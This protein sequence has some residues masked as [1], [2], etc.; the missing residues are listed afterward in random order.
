MRKVTL[1]VLILLVG[2][3]GAWAQAVTGFTGG[4][5]YSSY[6]GGTVAGDVVGYRFTVSSPLSVTELGV[7]NADTA[8]GGAGM[9]SSHETGIWD[10]SQTLLASVTVIPGGPVVGN[11][12]YATIT[13]VVLSPGET[14]TIGTIYT[15]TDNDN[16]ISSASS[17]T[18]A[19]EVTFL[20]SVYPAAIDLGFVY[21]TMDSSSFGR[22]GPNFL[23]TVVPV[24]LQSFSIE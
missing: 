18:T 19:P 2:A 20:N 1:V 3:T 7:W 9:T 15:T 11:W 24:E 17:M 13:P 10:S 8:A 14:Y 23:F 4:T 16:Y 6:Y 12:V 22:F 21:P 5:E